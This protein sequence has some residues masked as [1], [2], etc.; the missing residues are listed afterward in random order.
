MNI[1]RHILAWIAPLLLA[2][3]A[4][5]VDMPAP[6]PEED[7]GQITFSLRFPEMNAA[8]RAMGDTP[9]LTDMKVYLLVFNNSTAQENNMMQYT[10]ATTTAITGN[11][12]TF[13]AT[14]NHTD[15]PRVVHIIAMHGEMPDLIKSMPPERIAVPAL[16]N[17]GNEDAYWGRV[18]LD[19]GIQEK[20]KDEVIQSFT[21]VPMLRN[22]AKVTINSTP[23]NFEITGYAIV[24]RPTRGTVAPFD[25]TKGTFPSFVG[26]NN[27]PLDYAIVAAGY[28]GYN[29]P[30]VTVDN[31]NVEELEWQ[32]NVATPTYIYERRF[33]SNS[34][35]YMLIRARYNGSTTETYYKV[36]LGSKD[37]TTGIFS[38]YHLLRNFEYSVNITAVNAAGFS[39][40][41]EAARSAAFNNFS[42]AVETRNI[43]DI[44]DGQDMMHVNFVTYVCVDGEPF[45]LYYQYEENIK[46]DRTTN[47][48]VVEFL[49]NQNKGM[50]IADWTD[51]RD[52][53]SD[54]FKE[55]RKITITP[56]APTDEVKTETFT[57]YKRNGLSRQINLVLRNPWNFEKPISTDNDFAAVVAGTYTGDGRYPT[58]KFPV[59]DWKSSA[60]QTYGVN[61]DD[62]LTVYFELP[63]GLPEV[64]FPLTF[65]LESNRQNIYNN[66]VGVCVVGTYED[67]MFPEHYPTTNGKVQQT[68]SYYRPVEY[69]EYER[70]L[71]SNENHSAPICCRMLFNTSLAALNIDSRETIIRIDNPYFNQVD[72]K[73]TRRINQ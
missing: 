49:S 6:A 52:Q 38:Y 21:Y 64:M 42:A 62:P 24:N 43:L 20:N 2:S 14:L 34:H 48:D 37:R 60:N 70:K 50:V 19:N 73:F 45:D 51:N 39:T 41:G 40:A 68:I 3:C 4:S 18:V 53:S 72:V 46:G 36:D 28:S 11:T 66:P 67:T 71:A 54:P 5:E 29:A 30:D 9:D 10:T 57:L 32:V 35:T 58:T 56:N 61:I 47:N 12:A 13:K 65:R 17:E 55:Y 7:A 27:K 31:S 59:A 16:Y 22:F 69:D 63:A 1:K 15:Q 25:A 8:S 33:N 44:S 26:D 23:D